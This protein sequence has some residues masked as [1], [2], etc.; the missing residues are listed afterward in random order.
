MKNDVYEMH[1]IISSSP[2]RNVYCFAR[3]LLSGDKYGSVGTRKESKLLELAV[4]LETL[5]CQNSL[6]PQDKLNVCKNVLAKAAAEMYTPTSKGHIPA[7]LS[8]KDVN[9]KFDSID[10]VLVFIVTV[11]YIVTPMNTALAAVPSNDKEFWACFKWSG[12]FLL[13]SHTQ[14][15][16]KHWLFYPI[17]Y[18]YLSTSCPL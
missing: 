7:L 12:Q 14:K 17:E 6:T 2:W 8:A 4:R 1:D 18:E 3:M 15:P 13:P 5:L 10:D 11:K 16:Y 9:D